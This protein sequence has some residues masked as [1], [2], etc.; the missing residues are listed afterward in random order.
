MPYTKKDLEELPISFCEKDQVWVLV[1]SFGKV[2][3]DGA[4][5]PLDGRTYKTG[6]II[7]FQNGQVFRASFYVNTA[8]WALID[9]EHICIYIDE[10]WYQVAEPELLAKLNLSLSDIFPLSWQTDRPLDR[11]GQGPF[12]LERT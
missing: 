1:E 5:I 2:S 6:G 9:P 4:K 12:I 10:V 11:Y 7:T 3:W 8:T